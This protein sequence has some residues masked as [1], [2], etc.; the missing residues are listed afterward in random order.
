MTKI[1]Y[2]KKNI[3]YDKIYMTKKIQNL[4]VFE[5]TKKKFF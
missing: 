5:K 2:D 4:M 3:M 1:M